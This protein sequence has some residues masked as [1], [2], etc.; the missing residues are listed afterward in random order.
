MSPSDGCMYT[1]AT[2]KR[3]LNHAPFESWFYCF[4]VVYRVNMEQRA[5]TNYLFTLSL[6][7]FKLVPWSCLWFLTK[8]G[9]AANTIGIG[10]A[11]FRTSSQMQWCWHTKCISIPLH[12]LLSDGNI[13]KYMPCVFKHK[14]PTFHNAILLAQKSCCGLWRELCILCY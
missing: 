12:T 3:Q 14:Y 2:G 5:Q 6:T 4:I 8:I 7:T 10:G 9:K 11:D 1:G 13:Y